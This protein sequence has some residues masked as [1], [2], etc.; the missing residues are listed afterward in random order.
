MTNRSWGHVAKCNAKWRRQF[1]D[2]R[3]FLYWVILNVPRDLSFSI[4]SGDMILM[5]FQNVFIPLKNRQCFRAW[6]DD[7]VQFRWDTNH[8]NI[9]KKCLLL[10]RSCSSPDLYI[11]HFVVRQSIFSVSC[12]IQAL[13][14]D[15]KRWLDSIPWNK[16]DH[17]NSSSDWTRERDNRHCRRKCAYR[18]YFTEYDSGFMNLRITFYTKLLFTFFFLRRIR[19]SHS[20]MYC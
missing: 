13:G 2:L 8:F 20:A 17:S 1:R 4:E 14:Y 12:R 15:C 16:K 3:S 6:F 19:I 9:L 10:R 7:I 5:I 11:E 18:D